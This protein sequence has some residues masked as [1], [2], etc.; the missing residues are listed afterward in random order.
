[1]GMGKEWSFMFFSLKE[2][3]NVPSSGDKGTK[4]GVKAEMGFLSG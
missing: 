1:M 4:E 3:G 2:V